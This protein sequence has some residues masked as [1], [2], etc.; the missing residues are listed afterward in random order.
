MITKV[1][2][3]FSN[4]IFKQNQSM[5]STALLFLFSL[6]TGAG[7]A[8]TKNTSNYSPLRDPYNTAKFF[9]TENGAFVDYFLPN[10]FKI[11]TFEYDARVRSYYSGQKDTA[12][13]REDALNYYSMDLQ[14]NKESILLPKQVTVGQ[15]WFEADSSWSYEILD[16]NKTYKTP[17]KTY[18]NLV[19]VLCTQLTGRDKNKSQVYHLFYAEK[20]GFVGSVSSRNYKCYLAKTKKNPKIG[21]VFSF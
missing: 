8:Q 13:L 18:K 17:A 19:E 5:K 21:E 4:C 10:T 3:F 9:A 11:G 6:L 16:I 7:F 2:I 14:L 15:K 1:L 20:L 12:Y